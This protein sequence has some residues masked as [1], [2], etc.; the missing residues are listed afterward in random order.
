MCIFST[1]VIRR[2]IRN[3]TITNNTSINNGHIN[4]PSYHHQPREKL[5]QP[6]MEL[7][8]LRRCGDLTPIERHLVERDHFRMLDQLVPESQQHEKRLWVAEMLA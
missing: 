5:L 4:D 6:P 2:G 3:P 8:S 7:V 1:L